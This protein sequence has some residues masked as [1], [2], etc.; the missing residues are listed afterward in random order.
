[1][2]QKSAKTSFSLQALLLP[3]ERRCLLASWRGEAGKVAHSSHQKR[4]NSL[5]A[6]HASSS[7]SWT[8]AFLSP[9]AVD[10]AMEEVKPNTPFLQPLD[11]VH[12]GLQL[13]P[14]GRRPSLLRSR[15]GT[16]APDV[17]KNGNVLG[18]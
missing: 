17:S 8:G 13:L 7:N 6:G 18:T 11:Q 2:L 15:L 1:M 9:Q 5:E 3:G 16:A 12:V 14:T 4:R 10:H